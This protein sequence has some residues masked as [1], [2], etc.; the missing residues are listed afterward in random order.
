MVGGAGA[1]RSSRGAAQTLQ[2]QITQAETDLRAGEQAAAH[3][4]SEMAAQVALAQ[5][6]ERRAA[7]ERQRER[8]ATELAERTA[9]HERIAARLADLQSRFAVCN[10]N[11]LT[12][13]Q[14]YAAACL[15]VE[16][17]EAGLLA[18]RTDRVA[19]GEQLRLLHDRMQIAHGEWQARKDEVHAAQLAAGELQVRTQ[20]LVDRLRDEHQIDLVEE[21]KNAAATPA[22][23]MPAEGSAEEEIEEL[24][25]KLSR[26][27]AVNLDSLQELA[28]LELRQGALRVQYDDLTAAQ[29][30][31]MDI[32]TTINEDSRR[33]FAETFA[34][35][36]ANF[37][38][39][40]RRLSAG[41]RPT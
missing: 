1:L 20:G 37:Q 4:Q 9:V 33:L 14:H 13:S 41:A 23:E 34:L 5:I 21:S 3:A 6:E 36:R 11:Q 16:T 30:S 32:I 25:R 22:L 27:G 31:L 2:A 24:R 38:D 8:L 40:F 17:A 19:V 39:L 7:A 10:L 28:E 35:V 15:A 29:K 26:L 12:A 18:L